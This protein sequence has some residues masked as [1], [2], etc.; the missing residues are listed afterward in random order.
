[1]VSRF[2]SSPPPSLP[3]PLAVSG[4]RRREICTV[5]LVTFDDVSVREVPVWYT[6]IIRSSSWLAGLLIGLSVG[7]SVGRSVFGMDWNRTPTAGYSTARCTVHCF[8][9]TVQYCIN[10][11]LTDSRVL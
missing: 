6:V 3:P 9:T 1:M 11:V 7:R 5:Q 2:L 4:Y 8:L 10:K